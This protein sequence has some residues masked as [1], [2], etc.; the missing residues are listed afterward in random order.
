MNSFKQIAEITSRYL[1]GS[2]D[3]ISLKYDTPK[4]VVV[5]IDYDDD[6]NY[7]YEYDLD[8]DMD[9]RN[10]HFMGHQSKTVLYKFKV[11][12]DEHFENALCTYLCVNSL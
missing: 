4:H 9:S 10:V 5:S 3:K 6:F 8:I 1:K 11:D 12:R 2:L 7:R